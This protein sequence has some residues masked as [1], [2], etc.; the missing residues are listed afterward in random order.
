M[1]FP[2]R[3][4]IVL[5]GIPDTAHDQIHHF[6]VI[7]DTT[8]ALPIHDKL[9]SELVTNKTMREPDYFT[10]IWRLGREQPLFYYCFITLSYKCCNYYNSLKLFL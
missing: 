9:I 8:D 2:F 7:S 5:I 6:A 3:Y 1:N 10:Y 4:V